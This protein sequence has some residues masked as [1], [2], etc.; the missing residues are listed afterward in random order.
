[1]IS[2]IIGDYDMNILLLY[3]AILPSLLLGFYIYK[4]D[5]VEKEP[6]SMLIRIFIGGILSGII[7]ILLSIFTGSYN[8]EHKT[9]PE[10]LFYSFV[11]VALIEELI[12]FLMTYLICYKDKE[13]NYQYDGIVYSCFLALGFA[14]YENI[15]YAYQLQDFVTILYRS[16][17]TVPAHVFFAVFM[18]YYLGLA[19]HYRRYKSIK[20]ERKYLILSLL[21]PIIL[22]GFFDFCL[23]SG[24]IVGLI[25]FLIFLLTLYIA[26]FKKVNQTSNEEKHI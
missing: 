9:M 6:L 15:L 25:F 5:K 11:I 3:L 22:H 26:S 23:F 21:T 14:T 17:L 24:N 18:G 8:Y 4:K 7:V 20:K 19:K 2:F 12:K 1:M 10:I 16:V 13:F